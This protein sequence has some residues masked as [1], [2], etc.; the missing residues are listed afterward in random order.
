[1]SFKAASERVE[2]DHRINKSAVLKQAILAFKAVQGSISPDGPFEFVRH[3]TG[4]VRFE[5]NYGM[6]KTRF[7]TLDISLNCRLP[8]IWNKLPPSLRR[9]ASVSVF[10]IRLTELFPKDRL[11]P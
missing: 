7:A 6:P 2:G 4:S 10:E 5:G 8:K 1:M 11:A 9:A 3:P